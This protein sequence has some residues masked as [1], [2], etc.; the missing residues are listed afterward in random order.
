MGEVNFALLEVA[1]EVYSI[2]YRKCGKS[3][4]LM[5]RF[6]KVGGRGKEN[7]EGEAKYGRKVLNE[8][9]KV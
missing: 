8:G 9:Q 4:S 3:Y 6:E 1:R 5:G 2:S 7:L